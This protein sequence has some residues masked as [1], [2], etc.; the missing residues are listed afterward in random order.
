MHLAPLHQYSSNLCY[1][2]FF[3][4]SRQNVY[5][6]ASITDC[7]SS[8]LQLKKKYQ[9]CENAVTMTSWMLYLYPDLHPAINNQNSSWGFQDR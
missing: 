8:K 4:K 2:S 7:K 3:T 9:Q 5:E 6:H 1:L